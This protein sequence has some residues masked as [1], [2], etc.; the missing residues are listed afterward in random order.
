MKVKILLTAALVALFATAPALAA[1]Q[2]YYADPMILPDDSGIQIE[3]NNIVA[4]DEPLGSISWTYPPSQYRYYRLYYTLYNPTDH[5]I[6]Y[7]FNINFVDS[8]GTVYTTE[9]NI[10]AYGLGAGRRVSDYFKEYPIPR[11]ATGLYLRW[12]HLNTYV[13]EYEMTNI[14]L[15]LQATP[16]PAPT[17]TVQPTATPAPSPTPNP[18]PVS[19]LLPLA[20][21]GMI[22][23][24]FCAMKAY[25]DYRAKR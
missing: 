16:T 8:N 10:L 14:A 5:D 6:R 22:A 13:N 21:L 23:C 17:A 19:G 18:A 7:Q 25:S 4:S 24:G 2:I 15:Q 9:D 12:R 3:L 20:A 11:N 1:D